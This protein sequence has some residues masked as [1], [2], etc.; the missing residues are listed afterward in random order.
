MQAAM[1]SATRRRPS[2]SRKVKIPP[3]DDRRPPSNLT[4]TFLPETGERPGSGSIGSLI[5]GV[6][7]LKVALFR[8]V[9]KIIRE[10]NDVGYIC[11]L[12]PNYAG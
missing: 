9:V 12:Q 1:R 11:K 8:F 2:I 6:A 7:F 3:S 10:I 4:T 5:A